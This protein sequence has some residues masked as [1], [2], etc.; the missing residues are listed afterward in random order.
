MRIY[1]SSFSR[2]Q[3]RLCRFVPTLSFHERSPSPFP[4]AIHADDLPPAGTAFRV[5]TRD[6]ID[7]DCTQAAAKFRGA[8]DDA[9][10]FGGDV[11]VPRGA[12][13]CWRLPRCNRAADER[14]DLIEL[15]V[16]P[17]R[18]CGHSYLVVTSIS[19]TKSQGEAKKSAGKVMGGAGL[20][21]IVG[22]IAGSTGPG[23]GL[24]SQLRTPAET[25]QHYELAADQ[26]T[27]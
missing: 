21:A 1:A 13:L 27:Q 17:I 14:H 8:T 2:W 20:G 9:I 10:M 11:I 6:S 16:N 4:C 15:K 18:V 7:V 19:Q 26:K 25:G 23:N 22:G 5:R 24:W 3:L 12:A